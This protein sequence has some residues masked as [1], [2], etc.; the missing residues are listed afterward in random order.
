MAG[1][2]FKSV[3]EYVSSQPDAVQEVLE[4]VRATIRKAVPA[5][6]EIISYNMPTYKLDD[7]R[8]V[9]VAVW[10]RHYSLYAATTGVAAAFQRELA[11]YEVIK[12]TI[13]FPLSL[14]VPSSLIE[15]IVKFRAKEVRDR[16]RVKAA[17]RKSR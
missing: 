4:R 8:V 17:R 3:D 15:R 6:K 11:D 2:V 9:Q 14:P 1:S 16:A 5:A 10:K 13:R 12:G 7:E